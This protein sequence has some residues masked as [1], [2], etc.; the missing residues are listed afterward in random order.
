MCRDAERKMNAACAVKRHI[1][2]DVCTATSTYPSWAVRVSRAAAIP[3]PIKLSEVVSTKTLNGKR[4][5]K[6]T[7]N[8]IERLPTWFVELRD[9]N[10]TV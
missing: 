7:V 10:F 3:D 4:L 8:A 6:E 5:V 2:S 1:K 9:K